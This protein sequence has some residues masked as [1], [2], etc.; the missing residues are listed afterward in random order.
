M[1]LLTTTTGKI[2]NIINT[3]GALVNTDH[4]TWACSGP[5]GFYFV[6]G[7]FLDVCAASF[8]VDF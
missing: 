3:N 6:N 2:V 4:M 1:D 5:D 8:G 7:Q